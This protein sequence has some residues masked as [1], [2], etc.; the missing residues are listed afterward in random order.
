MGKTYSQDLREKVVRFI[1]QGGGKSEAA[2]LFKIGRATIHRWL[3]LHASGNLKP[4]KRT[5]FHQKMD[6]EQ[7][8]AY[9]SANPDHTLKEIGKALNMA[10][11]TVFT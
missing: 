1:K 11:Q 2:S 3:R 4:K 6:V 9:V 5:S 8:K 7:L 10:Y